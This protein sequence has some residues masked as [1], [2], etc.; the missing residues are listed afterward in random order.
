MS[1]TQVAKEIFI[2]D[3]S[4]NFPRH[5]LLR[6]M[7]S[8]ESDAFREAVKQVTKAINEAKRSHL[9]VSHLICCNVFWIGVSPRVHNHIINDKV[10]ALLDRRCIPKAFYNPDYLPFDEEI[11]LI[12]EFTFDESMLAHKDKNSCHS[13]LSTI[14]PKP[15]KVFAPQREVPEEEASVAAM[16]GDSDE[17]TQDSWLG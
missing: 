9:L 5:P 15:K 2:K 4:K 11:I 7:V 3:T 12:E 1:K 14:M 16:L 8:L 17:E 6:T 13:D 10:R